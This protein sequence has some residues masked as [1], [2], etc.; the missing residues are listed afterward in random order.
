MDPRERE[1]RPS[2]SGAFIARVTLT[3]SIW[4]T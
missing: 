4:W 2:A 3:F 1:D